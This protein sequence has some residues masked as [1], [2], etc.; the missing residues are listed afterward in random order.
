VRENFIKEEIN[1]FYRII[2]REEDYIN[3]TTDGMISWRSIN[4]CTLDSDTGMEN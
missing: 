1:L 4:S 3:P 2:P